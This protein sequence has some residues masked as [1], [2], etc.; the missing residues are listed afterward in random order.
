M[1][2]SVDPQA[3]V[4]VAVKWILVRIDRSGYKTSVI[5]IANHYNNNNNVNKI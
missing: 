1:D 5:P 4:V 3:I 2:E